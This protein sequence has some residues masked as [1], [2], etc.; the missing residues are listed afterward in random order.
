MKA[1]TYLNAWKGRE[2]S[3]K[4]GMEA[5]EEAELYRVSGR[6]LEDCRTAEQEKQ[7]RSPG[8]T[9][10]EWMWWSDGDRGEGTASVRLWESSVSSS[11]HSTQPCDIVSAPPPAS[12]S[13]QCWLTGAQL[14]A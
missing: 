3:G 11:D 8:A 2:E 14:S 13:D 10:E 7:A 5:G 4:E 9:V 1:I 6:N 12:S